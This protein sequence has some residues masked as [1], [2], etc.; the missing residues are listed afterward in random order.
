[1]FVT[2]EITGF[3]M[4]RQQLTAPAKGWFTPAE[5]AAAIEVDRS[6]VS[7]WC[8]NGEIAVTKVGTR[9]RITLDAL[10]TK[11]REQTGNEGIRK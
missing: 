11:I 10:K 5:A 3:T 2:A 1:M 8:Q 6:T 9:Y 7:R 4:P